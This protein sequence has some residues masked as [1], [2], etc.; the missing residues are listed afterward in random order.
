M[1]GVFGY[2]S[3]SIAVKSYCEGCIL[4]SLL[5]PLFLNRK[6]GFVLIKEFSVTGFCKGNSEGLFALVP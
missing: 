2:S 1:L 4:V 5:D 6:E 3:H